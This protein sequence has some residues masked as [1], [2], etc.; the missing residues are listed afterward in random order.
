[1]QTHLNFYGT[2]GYKIV[3]GDTTFIYDTTNIG[4]FKVPLYTADISA[5][6][7]GHGVV[8]HFVRDNPTQGE[9]GKESPLDFHDGIFRDPQTDEK[10]QPGSQSIPSNC[11]IEIK[12]TYWFYQNGKN[13]YS[14]EPF[15]TFNIVEGVP[16]LAS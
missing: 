16:T 4:R 12:Q 5:P 13:N 14:R 9:I 6:G 11:K 2:S 8:W 1:M 10:V 3:P 7:F 15:L